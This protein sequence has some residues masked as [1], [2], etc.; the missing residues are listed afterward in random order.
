[1][2]HK[3][4]LSGIL[5]AAIVLLAGCSSKQKAAPADPAVPGEAASAAVESDSL[6]HTRGFDEDPWEP[7]NRTMFRFN[8]TVDAWV[9]E[10]VAKGY[11]Y[12]LP[13]LVKTGVG[14]FFDNLWQPLRM[15]S[16]LFQLKLIQ[17]GEQTGRFL[18]NSTA[19]I[20]G[21]IDVAKRVGLPRQDEDLGTLLAHYGVGAGPYVV[22]PFWGPSDLRDSFTRVGDRFLNP[23][24]YVD[25]L[26]ISAGATALEVV[27]LR[28]QLLDATDA[29]K[30]G[31]LDYYI[32]LRNSYKQ[33]RLSLIYDGEL[34]VD[35]ATESVDPL[36]DPNLSK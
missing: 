1:M 8:D 28:R 33:R 10:P 2:Y 15:I 30:K 5:T 13:G 35:S 20:A 26:W 3:T 32:F 27:D 31:S 4:F 18:V 21:L 34:P 17:S 36:D 22:L 6:K 25:N 29:G 11:D 23:M 12:V 14:N 9:L 24:Y 7:F 19:G 16:A